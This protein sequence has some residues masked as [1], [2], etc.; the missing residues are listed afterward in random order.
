[1]KKSEEDKNSK[2]DK[3][4]KNWELKLQRLKNRR[5]KEDEAK[6]LYRGKF[7][8]IIAWAD[9]QADFSGNKCYRVHGPCVGGGTVVHQKFYT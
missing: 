9:V 5:Q 3:K 8:K 6:G 2:T 4:I 1:M 7:L